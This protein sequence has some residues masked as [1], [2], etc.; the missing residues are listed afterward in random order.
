MDPWFLHQ[1][2]EVTLAHRIRMA[3]CLDPDNAGRSNAA[4]MAMMAM[5]TRSSMSVKAG[6]L[7]NLLPGR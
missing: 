2:R 4:R 5:T 7:V 6:P 1:V 3:D